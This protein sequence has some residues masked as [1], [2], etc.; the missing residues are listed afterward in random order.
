MSALD[1]MVL[2]ARHARV[3]A[4]LQRQP[5]V[6]HLDANL[7]ARETGQF[8]GDDEG[9]GG[10]AQVDGRRPALRTRRGH[11]LEPMLNGEQ[12]AERIPA[13]KCH[14]P[15]VA[16]GPVRLVGL[17]AGSG[18]ADTRD[19]PDR[20]ALPGRPALACYDCQDLQHLTNDDH[21]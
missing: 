2:L 18:A 10:F 7:L 14:D 8:G 16:R 17:A 9:V 1:L 13:C 3:A 5:A 15:M 11:P 21:G 6:V 4:A 12:I 19:P 20:P